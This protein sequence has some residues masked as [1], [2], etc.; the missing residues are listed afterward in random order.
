MSKNRLLTQ[1][2]LSFSL[3]TPQPL[4]AFRVLFSPMVS[5]SGWT[6]R[7][8]FDQS[9]VSWYNSVRSLTTSRN[10]LNLTLLYV[11]Q[12]PHIFLYFGQFPKL[13]F[14]KFTDFSRILSLFTS[15]RHIYRKWVLLVASIRRKHRY[16]YRIEIHFIVESVS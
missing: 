10:Q 5:G 7:P 6:I 13:S 9:S 8:T 16:S 2:F 12:Y 15:Y 14:N 3:F 4:R 1:I 11:S